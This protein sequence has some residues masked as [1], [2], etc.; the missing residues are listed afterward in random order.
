MEITLG[1]V[2]HWITTIGLLCV[3]SRHAHWSV[4]LSLILT[5]VSFEIQTYFDAVV[6]EALKKI[7]ANLK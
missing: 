2:I 4:T 1:A 5:A 3:V 6:T 7:M